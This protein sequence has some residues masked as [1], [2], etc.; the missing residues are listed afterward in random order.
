VPGPPDFVGV[1]TQRCGTTWWFDLI[2]AH[3]SVATALDKERHFFAR[4]CAEPMTDADVEAY[5]R[6]FYREEGQIAGEWTPRYAYDFWTPPLLARA[7]PGAKLMFLVRDPVAR[8]RSGV[9]HQARLTPPWDA[10][11]LAQICREAGTRGLYAEPLRRMLECFPREQ[12]LVLQYERCVADTSAELR[13][14]FNYLGVDEDFIPDDLHSPRG[15]QVK[16]EGGFDLPAAAHEAYVREVAEDVA[17]LGA[18]VP[19]LDLTL[20]PDFAGPNG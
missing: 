3:P 1:G 6:S 8:L 20:W 15:T 9:E 5:R 10:T 19:E 13:R 2:T 4:F 16:R 7:A 17:E 18:L 14:T 11:Q 12:V